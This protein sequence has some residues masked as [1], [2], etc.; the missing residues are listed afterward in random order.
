[1]E[2]TTST[3]ETARPQREEGSGWHG[4]QYTLGLTISR[5]FFFFSLLLGLFLGLFLFQFSVLCVTGSMAADATY[6]E[7]K[8]EVR[9]KQCIV[10]I[11]VIFARQ[12]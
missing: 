6:D 5:L 1:M 10:S 7:G 4:G 2:K 12:T 11:L 3:I 9:L 8:R